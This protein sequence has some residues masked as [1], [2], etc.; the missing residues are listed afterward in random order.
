[1]PS[2]F[3]TLPDF[4]VAPKILWNFFHSL[5]F[6]TNLLTF[7]QWQT[8]RE[9]VF[10]STTKRFDAISQRFGKAEALHPCVRGLMYDDR[11]DITGCDTLPRQKSGIQFTSLK[12]RI[13]QTGITPGLYFHPNALE[14][15]PKAVIPSGVV[16]SN[17]SESI[18]DLL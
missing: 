14:V 8:L 5:E 17:G 2:C 15:T 7:R 3:F 16:V 12:A 1:M 9:S 10:L 13:V 4:S 18:F 6:I 11:R